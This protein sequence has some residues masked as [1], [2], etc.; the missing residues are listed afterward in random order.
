MIK[1]FLV[2][3]FIIHLLNIFDIKSGGRSKISIQIITLT[4]CGLLLIFPSLNAKP[5][6]F[7]VTLMYSFTFSVLLWVYDKTGKSTLQLPLITQG[8]LFLLGLMA[9]IS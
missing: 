4:W 1:F 6:I 5:F 7:L 9:L 8:L 3:L 2:V